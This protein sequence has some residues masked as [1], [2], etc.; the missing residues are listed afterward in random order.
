M[1]RS[2]TAALA[3]AL[4]WALTCQPPATASAAGPPAGDPLADAR[5][6]LD[7]DDARGAVARLEAVLPV[8][9]A[10]DR[11]PLIDLLRTAYSAAARRAEAEGRRAEADGYRDNLEILNR[12]LR[13]GP[14]PARSPSKPGPP[15]APTPT[16]TTATA[17]PVPTPAE[18]AG[19]DLTTEPLPS[20]PALAPPATSEPGPTEPPTSPVEAPAPAQA[21]ASR[22]LPLRP[23]AVGRP[24]TPE[25]DRHAAAAAAATPPAADDAP[26]A[27]SADQEFLAARYDQAGRIYAALDRVHALPADRRSHWA[28][29]RA[30]AVVRRINARPTD[31]REW[32]AID[33][34]VGAVQALSPSNWFGEYLRKLAQERRAGAVRPPTDRTVVRGSSPEDPPAPAKPPARRFGRLRATPAPAPPPNPEPAL[35]SPA[36]IPP[37]TS[38]TGDLEPPTPIAW[39]AQPVITANFVVASVERDRELAGRVAEAAESARETQLRHWAGESARPETPWTPRCEIYLFPSAR[40]FSR[41]THQPPESPGFSSMGMNAGKIV[42]RRVHLRTDHPS[43]VR[44]VLPHEVTHVVLADLFPRQQIP[45]WADEGMAVLSEPTREQSVHADELGGPLREN[46]LFRLGA[47]ASMDYPDPRYMTLYYAQSVSLTRFL[48]ESGTPTQFVRFLRESQRIGVEP[49]LATVYAVTGYPDLEARWLA[50]ARDHA[51]SPA[52]AAAAKVA[53]ASPAGPGAESEARSRR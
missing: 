6:S 18:P 29:C 23:L 24:E 32:S 49:A 48:V 34:E 30:V 31:A 12:K 38:T 33:A 19:P 45:R 21:P 28:Y 1:H 10:A 17:T 53:S 43:L 42:L 15:P 37:P 14:T 9:S 5:R 39:T 36:T 3:A 47:L 46:R 11:P 4:A 40:E 22:T 8:A 26:S 41:E 7:R 51:A 44:A 2:R 50:Y 25:P 16:P 27:R 20:A 52:A 35:I 13:P